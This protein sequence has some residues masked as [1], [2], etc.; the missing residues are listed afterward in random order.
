MLIR[1]PHCKIKNRIPEDRLDEALQ[2]GRCHQTIFEGAVVDLSESEWADIANHSNRLMVIDFWAEW[3]GPCKTM[4]PQF[5]IVASQLPAI[6]FAK[7]NTD[8]APNLSSTLAIRSIPTLLL[9]K[10]GRELDRR[11]GAMPASALRAWLERHGS[12]RS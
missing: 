9:W 7:I 10:N 1:C 2:C 5:E 4:A 12:D 3:C 8:L 6:R 11:A